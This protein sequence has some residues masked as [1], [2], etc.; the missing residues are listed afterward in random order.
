MTA[1]GKKKKGPRHSNPNPYSSMHVD[2]FYSVPVMTPPWCACMHEGT[3]AVC[4]SQYMKET[5]SKILAKSMLLNKALI[6]RS[7]S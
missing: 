1:C 6:R 7:F 3:H 2:A 4:P 5:E